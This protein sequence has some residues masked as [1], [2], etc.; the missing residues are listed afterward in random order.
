MSGLAGWG[1]RG[2][3]FTEDAEAGSTDKERKISH[4]GKARLI[5]RMRKHGPF[6]YLFAPQISKKKI[7]KLNAEAG[8]TDK[9]PLGGSTDKERRGCVSMTFLVTYLPFK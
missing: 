9:D 6:F 1:N 3:R 7:S 4:P 8:S 2:A 5:E